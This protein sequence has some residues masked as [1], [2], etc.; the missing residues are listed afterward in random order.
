M[1]IQVGSFLFVSLLALTPSARADTMAMA[2]TQDFAQTA[3][4]WDTSFV[5]N[6]FDSS[7]GTL[8]GVV[9]TLTDNVKGSAGYENLT[10]VATQVTMKLDASISLTALGN[11]S[12]IS[13]LNLYN[14]TTNTSAY[15]GTI[16]FQGSS[17]TTFSNLTGSDSKTLTLGLADANLGLYV[18]NGT[19]T[20]PVSARGI[21]SASGPGNLATQFSTVAGASAQVRYLF[22]P[23]PEPTSVALMGIGG[24]GLVALGRRKLAAKS[25]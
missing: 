11:Q 19:F 1:R 8:T 2:Q 23:V 17:G 21:S 20:I 7:L 6:K 25:A 5:F 15:D 24:L 16:N 18:G 12:L 4:N 13:S 14:G 10:K 9:I 22:T 3:S